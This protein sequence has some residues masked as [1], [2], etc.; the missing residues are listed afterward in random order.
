[1]KRECEYCKKEMENKRKDAIFCSRDCK[2]NNR[3]MKKYYQDRK[4]E[5]VR[6][7]MLKVEAYKKLKESLERRA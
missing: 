4:E 3:R 6:R 5:L 1:M 2:M 7:E